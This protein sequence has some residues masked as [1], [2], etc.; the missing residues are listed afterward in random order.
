MLHEDGTD[1]MLDAI[2]RIGL[3][4]R[5]PAMGLTWDQAAE[6]LMGMRGYLETLPLWHSIAH[7]AAITPGFVRD[8]RRRLDAA[9]GDR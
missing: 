9:Y 4:I 6:G 8:L 5:P 7:D 1:R 2:T 3:D